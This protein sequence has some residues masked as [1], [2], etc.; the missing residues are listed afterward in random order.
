METLKLFMVAYWHNKYSSYV[1]GI[2]I[3]YLVV[4]AVLLGIVFSFAASVLNSS[5]IFRQNMPLLYTA[6]ASL[7]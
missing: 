5:L 7:F 1:S 3:K 4:T 2:I 6:A